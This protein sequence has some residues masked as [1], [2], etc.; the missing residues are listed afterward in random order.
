MVPDELGGRLLRTG[1]E[2]DDTSHS[3]WH[4]AACCDSL[5]RL[6]HAARSRLVRAL[7][8]RERR[9][10][11]GA[12]GRASRSARRGGRWTWGAA[13][14]QRVR[15]TYK[16][17]RVGALQWKATHLMMTASWAGCRQRFDKRP[18]DGGLQP[19][20]RPAGGALQRRGARARRQRIRSRRLRLRLAWLRSAKRQR[21]CRP[22]NGREIRRR[23]CVALRAGKAAARQR[24]N[25]H[26]PTREKR[27]RGRAGALRRNAAALRGVR[28]C[29]DADL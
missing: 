7:D 21:V 10:R 5:Q 13:P 26:A 3:T 24:G 2:F 6:D 14:R 16:A 27:Q 12:A 22:R 17:S 25:K 15:Y 8:M 23:R 11:S 1:N 20:W 9:S 19:E 4:G 29:C 28:R 18:R